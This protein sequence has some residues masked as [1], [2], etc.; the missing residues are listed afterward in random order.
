MKTTRMSIALAALVVGGVLGG[1]AGQEAA[2]S[3]DT[4]GGPVAAASASNAPASESTESTAQ[5]QDSRQLHIDL[6]RGS[7]LGGRGTDSDSETPPA[8][9]VALAEEFATCVVDHYYDALSDTE[10]AELDESI[11]NK[12]EP[13][14]ELKDKIRPLVQPCRELLPDHP[15]FREP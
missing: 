1:C 10:L 9:L 3:S 11:A 12:T 7:V 13:S 15:V 14:Q 6:F 8:E 5:K 2:P 4:T